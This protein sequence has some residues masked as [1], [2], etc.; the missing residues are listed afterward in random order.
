ML[1][2]D[3]Q[4][5]LA[6]ARTAFAAGD[7]ASALAA[8]HRAV[9][10]APDS[11]EA[12]VLAV[13][14]ALRCDQLAIAVPWLEALLRAHPG[15]PQFIR[16]L[17]TAHNNLGS[18]LQVAGEATE[19]LR[20]FTRALGVWPDNPEALF[21]RA[22]LALD[23][24]QSARALPDLQRLCALRPDDTGAAVLL[25]EAQIASDDSA[26]PQMGRAALHRL[27]ALPGIDA[28][29][30]ALARAD[31]GDTNGALAVVRT[32]SKPADI[33]RGVGIAYRIAESSD[34]RGARAAFGHLAAL[35]DPTQ[36]L[37]LAIAQHLALPQ[38]Y[39]SRDA[40]LEQRAIYSAGVDALLADYTPTRLA[41]LHPRL[42]QLDWSNLL[43]AYQGCNDIELQRK[44]G[45]FVGNCLD[46]FAPRLRAPLAARRPGAP[47]VGF[48]SSA[49]RYST[50]GSYFGSWVG[51]AHSD[52]HD[53]TV[54]QLGP[55]F[56]DFTDRIGR[57]ASR[58]VRLDGAPAQLA[59]TVRDA[60]LDVL[61]LP[62]LGVDGRI[63]VLAALSL[64]R[65]QIMAW[66]HPSTSGNDRIAAF[67]SCAEMEPP[68]AREHYSERLLLL[69]GI[70]T[71]Y[72][73]PPPPAPRTRAEL[74]LPDG[75][76]YLVPQAPY[77]M[78]PDTDAVLASIAACD[79]DGVVV[80]FLS[81]RPRSLAMLRERLR[82][83]FIDAG[84]VPDRQLRFVPMVPRSRFLELCAACD[85]MVDT[86]HW[87]GGNTTIDALVA[88]LPVVTV[89]GA[90]M[91]GRQSMGMLN[92]LGI[93][94]LVC[95]DA[96]SQVRMA[97]RVANER[98]LREHV[99]QRIRA[100]LPDLLGGAAALS[101][102]RAHLATLLT[103][104]DAFRA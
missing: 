68:D 12:L 84:A 39:P 78:H 23:A 41:G 42:E 56:D 34:A 1:T 19:A 36:S 62:D 73:Q 101:T 77:K 76:L 25:A 49:F 104:C 74:G 80:L 52:G 53:T 66:G 3:L 95:A 22:R 103:D 50:V 90:L 92:A 8:A 72:A 46:H 98:E 24:A 37:H 54:F 13:N 94:E 93:D 14:S 18:R 9:A 38:V 87:S 4:K 11:V 5:P 96:Q 35:G 20:S 71:A 15:N 81:E 97:L 26:D 99:G 75:R 40:L 79:P 21:N 45:Q 10:A 6:D 28:M 29:R 7:Y 83:A 43:L 51:A 32:I 100:R 59:Q 57:S 17:S 65:C 60:D 67:F 89:P 88:G 63:A 2:R 55:T 31:V 58:L 47:R 69:P 91:R 16:L 85:V 33:G 64:A 86:P 27:A 102:L 61:V 70:G 82:R 48:L 30:L 44:Y